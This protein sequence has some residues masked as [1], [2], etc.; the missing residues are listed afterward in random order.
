MEKNAMLGEN[1]TIH[2]IV[3]AHQ[4]DE[5]QVHLADGLTREPL[6]I[7]GIGC[8]F[9]GG[10]NSPQAFWDL[11][12]NGVDATREVPADR[13][14]VR[15]FYDPETKKPG[16]TQACRGGFLERIDQF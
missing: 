13:W 9:P 8:H 16:K 14:D 4:F 7:I 15:K 10:A 12:C 2:P 3:S 1:H 5:S 6:A 11:L